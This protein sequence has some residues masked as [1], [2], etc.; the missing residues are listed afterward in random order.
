MTNLF[1]GDIRETFRQKYLSPR[2]NTVSCRI[3]Y[4]GYSAWTF[5]PWGY[6]VPQI[7]LD[8]VSS[9]TGRDGLMATPQG[10]LF[11]PVDQSTP[12]RN[13]A[14]TSLWDNWPASVVVPV[15]KSADALWLLVCGSTNPM[16]GRI[17]NAVITLRY[18]DGKEEHFDLVPPFN[19]WSLCRFGTVDYDYNLDGF[20]LPANPPPQV[21]LGE[22]C[23]AMVYG[24]KLRPGVTLREVSLTTLSQEVVIGLMGV[25]M[26]NPR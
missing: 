15:N 14:F 8:K 18:S 24:C 7:S 20:A 5:K 23:R 4:D 10:A 22:N 25:S 19:F 11:D 2:P 6:G 26:M 21:Q 17:A 3:G 1:N 16:Q 12:A 13:I 9:L